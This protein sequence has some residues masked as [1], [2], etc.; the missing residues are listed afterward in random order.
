VQ[1]ITP[2]T[3]FPVEACQGSQPHL[4]RKKEMKTWSVIPRILIAVLFCAALLPAQPFAAGNPDSGSPVLHQRPD[5]TYAVLIKQATYDDPAW[6]AVADALLTKYDGQL[7]IWT[8]LINEVQGDLAAY[9]PTHVAMV[10]DWMTSSGPFVQSAWTFM[11]GLDADPYCDAVW[12]VV[13][14]YDAQDAL[15]VV[16]GPDGFEVKT[17]LSG[18]S[19]CD[20]AY[21]IQGISTNEA[22][23]NRYYV[24]HADSEET[25]EYNDGPTDRTEWLV[26]MLNEGV[27]IFAYDPVDIFYTSGHG[28]HNMWQMHYPS[29]GYEGYF[30]SSPGQAYGDPYSGPNININSDHPRIYFGL[31]NCNI[32]RIVNSGSMAPAWIHTGGA[33]HYTGYV[34]NEGSYSHQHGGTKAYFYRVARYNTWAESWYLGNQALR[35][36]Q[37][38]NTPGANPPDLNGGRPGY[39][40]KWGERHPAM[41]LPFRAE[42]I[43]ILYTDAITTVVQDDFVLLYAWYMNQPDLLEGETREV[44]FL[45][46]HTF[47]AVDE[48][49]APPQHVSLVLH[50]NHPNPFGPATR[51]S[52]ALPTADRVCLQV[53]NANGQVVHTVLDELQEAG[54]HSVLWNTGEL[55]SGLYFYR[56][57]AGEMSATRKA[58][59]L[60]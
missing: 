33:Y 17:V 28:A 18:T 12:A 19:S 32:G 23:Y 56:L 57:T 30:R 48:D 7:F 29:S 53:L 51:I 14:G 49:P 21:H 58:V 11:R 10:G 9:R 39:T 52:Y 37:I 35:F 41:I 2:V 25:T 3:A 27:D 60:K 38:N 20:L 26:T 5:M 47:S 22:T 1:Q 59:I 13:T 44:V 54:S 42:N 40:S 45:C 15:N 31:G 6:Q 50:Q 55:D 34:I 16:T 43:E 46:D 8:S 4:R 36:D 24:K